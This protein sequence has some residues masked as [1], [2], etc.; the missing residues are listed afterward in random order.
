MKAERFEIPTLI[1]VKCLQ[2]TSDATYFGQNQLT[3][4]ASLILQKRRP[5]QS[6]SETTCNIF[7]VLNTQ[8]KTT[9]FWPKP[10]I[11][12]VEENKTYL[13][14]VIPPSRRLS[15]LRNVSCRTAEIDPPASGPLVRLPGTCFWC[16]SVKTA[17]HV[18][19]P[20]EISAY[21]LKHGLIPCGK[22]T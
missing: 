20:P 21:S 22:G 10:K 15:V 4:N 17:Q 12:I 11:S 13:F 16:H 1:F 18:A 19:F 5:K 7:F 9:I 3:Q 8:K 14:G 2:L 6:F